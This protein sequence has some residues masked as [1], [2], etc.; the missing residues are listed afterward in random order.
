MAS[1]LAPVRSPSSTHG[2][3]RCG[4]GCRHAASTL[5]WPS[6]AF[7]LLRGPLD[8][9]VRLSLREQGHEPGP[10]HGPRELGLVL[11]S[12]STGLQPP[13]GPRDDDS[14]DTGRR[15]RWTCAL[16][17]RATI[18]CPSRALLVS[19]P[20]GRS[21]LPHLS[22]AEAAPAAAGG[23]MSAVLALLLG[24]AERMDRVPLTLLLLGSIMLG[25]LSSGAR[26][27]GISLDWP[28]GGEA[29]GRARARAL[30]CTRESAV[31][32][33]RLAVRVVRLARAL[34]GLGRRARR[35][36]LHCGRRVTDP[37]PVRQS[38]RRSSRTKASG[39]S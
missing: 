15:P 20:D 31:T 16:D 7:P 22:A 11:V 34:G 27:R 6:S 26:T 10:L 33:Y 12:S 25:H 37:L 8:H 14:E 18:L 38:Q 5:P 39:R 28:T 9:P 30:G 24:E 17:G 3:A 2:A 4:S 21:G 13:A 32:D 36:G 29:I 19:R 1:L 23:A 35:T